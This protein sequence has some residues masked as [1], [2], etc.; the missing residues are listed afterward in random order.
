MKSLQFIG[1]DPETLQAEITA[2]VKCQLDDFLKHFKP[3]QP[4]EYMTRSEVAKLFNVDISTI[5]NWQKSGKLNP[6]GIGARIYFLRSEVE[7]SVKP[8]NVRL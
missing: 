5:S 2:K 7:A 6:L 8:I 1:Y 4:N 3:K